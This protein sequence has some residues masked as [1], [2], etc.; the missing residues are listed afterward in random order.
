MKKLFLSLTAIIM[1]FAM[2]ILSGCGDPAPLSFNNDF[3]G[4][5]GASETNTDYTEVLT[6]SIERVD[7][8]SAI[9]RTDGLKDNLI[10]EY[11]GTYK[12]TFNGKP[13]TES[14]YKGINFESKIFYLKSELKL[15]VTLNEKTYNDHIINE[16][17]F[18]ESG[19]SLAPLW[20]RSIIKNTFLYITNGETVAKQVVLEYH[21]NYGNGS[22]YQSKKQYAPD[23]DEDVNAIDLNVIKTAFDTDKD[24][25]D[26]NQKTLIN[27]FKLMSDGSKTYE[28][29]TKRLI[30]NNQLLFAIR[31]TGL[32]SGNSTTIPTV[33]PVYGQAKDLSVKNNS[34]STLSIDGGLTYNG[35]TFKD[36][37]SEI[38]SIPVKNISFVIGG[39]DNVGTAQY[40]VLQKNVKTDTLSNSSQVSD[41]RDSYERSLPLVYVETLIEYAG[42]SH[43]GALKYTLKDVKIT[44]L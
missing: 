7:S 1:S 15:D 23:K 12:M 44:K 28:Y 14:P 16:T 27:K 39:T 26:E 19:Q 38:L 11:S 18:Y 5:G 29:Q 34:D 31:N 9:K 22:Y 43:L 4:G 21:T 8:Y 41:S 37:D 36:A 35:I 25:R 3:A 10:P 2:L 33:T 24:S 13:T 40:V 20:S 30:D 6:Y 42:F 17:Y 32:G